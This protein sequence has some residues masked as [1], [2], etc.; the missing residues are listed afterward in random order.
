MQLPLNFVAR[1]SIWA[2]DHD[3][4]PVFL[5]HASRRLRALLTLDFSAASVSRIQHWLDR[6]R[7]LRVQAGRA[8]YE[9]AQD[10]DT[11]ML[12]SFYL[13]EWMGRCVGSPP[14]WSLLALESGSRTCVVHFPEDHASG[15]GMIKL[16]GIVAHVWTTEGAD[17][18]ASLTQLIAPIDLRALDR[19]AQPLKPLRA[20][21]DTAF[22]ERAHALDPVTRSAMWSARLPMLEPGDPLSDYFAAQRELFERGNFTCGGVIQAHAD[23]FKPEYVGLRVA[24]VVYDPANLLR[25]DDVQAIA[26][27]LRQWGEAKNAEGVPPEALAVRAH[28][29]SGTSRML[30]EELPLAL[31]GYPLR[32]CSIWVDQEHLPDGMLS[33]KGVPLVIA[34][35]V[36]RHAKLLPHQAW[37]AEFRE[38]WLSAGQERLGRR[39]SITDMMAEAREQSRQ[40]AVRLLMAELGQ[41]AVA[42]THMD[43]G[44]H[45][46][47]PADV[48]APATAR[49]SGLSL[50]FTAIALAAMLLGFIAIWLVTSS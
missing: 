41:P 44:V 25:Y 26:K 32:I 45:A 49:V 35:E 4:D 50:K 20:D 28:L 3:A 30:S 21:R 36:S 8:L 5:K 10:G 15:L 22:H 6:Q 47:A 7:T 37:S 38:D 33:Y 18:A 34:P 12:L 23:L 2:L 40:I 11:L 9:H 42:Q 27:V 17:L 1:Q 16:P 19:S 48:P 46:D 14:S 31:F 29:R 13:A 39:H 24:E 43:A